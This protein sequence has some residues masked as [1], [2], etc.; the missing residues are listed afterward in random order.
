MIDD[1]CTHM[2]CDQCKGK[3]CYVCGKKAEELDCNGRIKLK[4]GSNDLFGH[5]EDWKEYRDKRCPLYLQQFSE[6]YSSCPKVDGDA[7][8]IWFHERYIFLYL[9]LY[10]SIYTACPD[11]IYLPFI[12]LGERERLS[13]NITILLENKNF[14]NY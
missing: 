11:D 2:S 7:A 14:A 9:Y 13:R 4:D 8:L 1:N 12:R 3:F 6:I 10:L 5:N